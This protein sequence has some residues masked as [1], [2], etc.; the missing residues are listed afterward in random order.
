MK[1]FVKWAGGKTQLLDKIKDRIPNSINNYYEPFV[2]G[3]AVLFELGLHNAYISDINQELINVYSCIKENV[4]VLMKELDIL[5][6]EH[7]KHLDKKEFYLQVREQYN[8]KIKNNV[9]DIEMAAKFI[10]LN[11]HCFNGLYRVNSKGLFNVPFN[12]KKTG[13]SYDKENLLEISSYLKN[14]NMLCQDFEKTCQDCKEGDFVFFD[15]PYAPL[16]PTSFESYTKEGFAKEEHIRLANLFKKLSDRGVNCMLTNHN[17]P[18]IRELYK[19]YNIEI[20]P[21]KRLINS[22]SK[23]REGEEVIITNYKKEND[24]QLIHGDA[25]EVLPSI[26]EKSIDMIFIDPPYFL[27]NGGITCS[28]GKQVSVNKGKWDENFSFEEKVDFNKKWIL[29]SKRILKDSGSIWISGTYHNIYIIGYLLEEL[30]FQI[31]NNVTWM[32]TNPPPNLSCRCFTHSTETLLWAKKK[33]GK[34]TFNYQLMKE[35]NEGKQMKDVFIGSLT[36]QREKTNGK[37]PTQKPEYL[38]EKIILASTREGDLVCDFMAGSFTT[39]VVCKKYN[40][41]FIGVEKEKDFYEL[42]LRRINEVI[43]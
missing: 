21:V 6:D 4:D 41:R 2:G 38:L 37:H 19:E 23:N 9:L 40:R 28:G 18:F 30:G 39:G 31:I 33:G 35:L 26:K 43:K 16:N 13:K 17:T 12:N 42:G 14:V 7:E 24:I 3:G 11:K 25:F 34:H 20:V 32:K 29:E 22:D 10:Y 5:C 27:S 8:E 1:P 15:S 36:P